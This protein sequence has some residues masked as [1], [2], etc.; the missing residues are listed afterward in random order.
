D[1]DERSGGGGRSGGGDGRSNDRGSLDD[2]LSYL[3][4]VRPLHPTLSGSSPAPVFLA[5]NVARVGN[6]DAAPPSDVEL[7]E[8]SAPPLSELDAEESTETYSM[9]HVTFATPVPPPFAPRN[10]AM[11]ST[12]MAANDYVIATPVA[13]SAMTIAAFLDHPLDPPEMAAFRDC[14][15]Q[16]STGNEA[17]AT[18]KEFESTNFGH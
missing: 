12:M 1:D 13:S 15:Q 11:A 4:S 7:I 17:A 9:P 6:D 14:H 18:N 5:A 8:P 16:P 3:S 10:H 2:F